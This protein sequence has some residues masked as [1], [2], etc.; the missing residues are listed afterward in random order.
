[1]EHLS[2]AFH[3]VELYAPK[4]VAV[5]LGLG[6]LYAPKAVA[7]GLGLRWARARMGLPLAISTPPQSC[8]T[9][10]REEEGEEKK[11]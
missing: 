6:E 9:P 3:I 8:A 1:M 5:G 2:S 11:K 4:A 7:V 10:V